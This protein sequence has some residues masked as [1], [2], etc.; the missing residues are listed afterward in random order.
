MTATN[1]QVRIVMRERRKGRTQEQAAAKSNLNSRKTV[2]KYKQVGKLPSELKEPQ[3]YRT[4]RDPFEEDWGEVE[5]LLTKASELEAKTLFEWL[6]E[7]KPEE[8]QEGQLRTLQLLVSTWRALNSEAFLTLEQEHQ[9]GEAM[10]T[11]GIWMNELM[12]T[13]NGHEFP[14]M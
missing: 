2:W 3:E 14:H 10:R 7:Q 9:P 8:Y 1:A 4:R 12:I 11:D 6:F 13:I 5:A